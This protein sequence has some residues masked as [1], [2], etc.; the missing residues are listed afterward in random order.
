MASEQGGATSGT[1][2]AVITPPLPR[3]MDAV[4]VALWLAGLVNLQAVLH[5]SLHKQL[6]A[7]IAWAIIWLCYASLM[8]TCTVLPY[9]G[10]PWCP[11]P[12]PPPP[13]PRLPCER[14]AALVCTRPEH[15]QR[16]GAGHEG[17]PLYRCLFDHNDA[18]AVP[19]ESRLLRQ[20]AHDQPAIDRTVVGLW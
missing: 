17:C 14:S 5:K 10:L 13:D 8:K 20:S 2:R 15:K 11:E 7:L 18:A 19:R 16:V 3:R 1:P 12:P 9:H 6:A 4:P